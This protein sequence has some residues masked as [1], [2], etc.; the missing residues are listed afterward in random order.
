MKTFPSLGVV[1]VALVLALFQPAPASA[2]A[3]GQAVHQWSY[4][5]ILRTGIDKMNSNAVAAAWLTFATNWVKT[6][7]VAEGDMMVLFP[8]PGSTNG[9][10]G[11]YMTNFLTGLTNLPGWATIGGGGGATIDS[12]SNRVL[13]ATTGARATNAFRR[14]Y[15]ETNSAHILSNIVASA[16]SGDVVEL[17]AG[18]F[19][20]GVQSIRPNEGTKFVGQGRGFTTIY[21]DVGGTPA[22]N[23]IVQIVSSVTYQGMKI[24]ANKKGSYYQWPMACSQVFNN[25]PAT[26]VVIRDVELDGDTDCITVYQSSF[27]SGTIEDCYFHSAGDVFNLVSGYN[28][29]EL[30]ENPPGALW[31]FRNTRLYSDAAL[32]QQ[33]SWAANPLANAFQINNSEAI[34]YN[35]QI[36]ATNHKSRAILINGTDTNRVSLFNSVV[37]ATGTNGYN[38]AIYDESGLGHLLTRV[39]IDGCAIDDSMISGTVAS[40]I[41]TYAPVQVGALRAS[42]FVFSDGAEAVGKV[43]QDVDGTGKIGWAE[44]IVGTNKPITLSA[45]T[46]TLLSS[47]TARYYTNA[48]GSFPFTFSGS[49]NASAIVTLGVSNTA[50]SSIYITNTTGIYDPTVASNVST[51]VIAPQSQRN[52]RFIRNATA[53][54]ELDATIGKEFELVPGS[55]TTFTTNGSQISIAASVQTN[56]NSLQITNVLTYGSTNLLVTNTAAILLDLSQFTIFRVGLMTNATFIFTNA[57]AGIQRAQVII[58]QDTNGQRTTAWSV[59]GGLIQTNASLQATTNANALDLLELATGYFTTN[60]IAWWPQ[61]FQPRVSFTNSFVVPPAVVF[62]DGFEETD[63]GGAL[64]SSTD[65]YDSTLISAETDTPQP[66]VTDRNIGDTGSQ[67]LKLDATSATQVSRWTIP[68]TTELYAKFKFQVDALPTTSTEFYLWSARDGSGNVQGAV[69]LQTSGAL[70]I[71]NGTTT[72]TTIATAAADTSYYVWVHWKSDGTAELGFSASDS[73]PTSGNSFQSV[74]GGNGTTAVTRVQLQATSGNGLVTW[75]DDLKHT[76]GGYP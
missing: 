45:G 59:A 24:T 17:G 54:W 28:P 23:P 56:A 25:A 76:T 3:S 6:N 73:R 4:T 34:F 65:G 60:L 49:P 44:S 29:G 50:S 66:D 36:V 42:S 55:A 38:Y 72:T 71:Y 48:G 31:T 68:S 19:Y 47:Q 40:P 74:T 21:G 67:S 2:A 39:Y 7:A 12:S 14:F 46:L 32:I 20:I 62:N 37:S 64:G 63:S 52:F 15:V 13:V 27:T 33:P 30:G 26:N 69:A 11:I 16:T 1:F 57:H 35:C 22:T 53:G 8:Q 41:V 51:F 61:N 43:L 70:R 5:D 10:R 58:Q 18:S 9:V 75:Y